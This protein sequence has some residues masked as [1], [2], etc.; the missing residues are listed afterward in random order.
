MPIDLRTVEA[1]KPGL[2]SWEEGEDYLVD[3]LS[4]FQMGRGERMREMGSKAADGVRSGAASL[5]G[6]LTGKKKEAKKTAG[7]KR[8]EKARAFLGKLEKMS[9]IGRADYLLASPFGNDFLAFCRSECND[10]NYRFLADLR[11]RVDD[12]TLI[13]Q[14]VRD[15]SVDMLNLAGPLR[16]AIVD[17]ELPVEGAKLA[18]AKQMNDP[19][20]RAKRNQTFLRAVG[21]HL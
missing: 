14:Y 9:Y 7:S 15:G 8:I 10:E 18:V 1:Q 20:H 4:E 3:P 5:A 19:W 21:A 11:N 6:A 2:R 13:E 12:A 17:G 16:K